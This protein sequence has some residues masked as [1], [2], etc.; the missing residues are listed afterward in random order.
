MKPLLFMLLLITGP[1]YLSAKIVNACH[2]ELEDANKSFKHLERLMKTP[3]EDHE[4]RRKTYM[5]YRKVKTKVKRLETCAKRTDE[6]LTSLLMEHPELY[7]EVS[8]LYDKIQASVDIYVEVDGITALPEDVFGMTSWSRQKD[9]PD[10]PESVYGPGTVRIQIKSCT[11]GKMVRYLVHELGHIKYQV[12]NLVEYQKYY[13][14]SYQSTCTELGHKCDD[15]SGFLVK[16]ELKR[17][18]LNRRKNIQ[19][20]LAS[21]QAAVD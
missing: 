12:P 5:Y 7:Y 4:L 11:K 18:Y 8:G 1:T 9:K 3:Q 2:C 20:G 21:K 14:Q 15:P 19:A 6:L 13:E 17:Y 10:S 16:Q